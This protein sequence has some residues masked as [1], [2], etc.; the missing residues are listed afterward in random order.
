MTS[1]PRVVIAGFG[2]TGVLVG[3]HLSRFADVVGISAKPGVVSGQ[4]LGLRLAHPEVWRRDYWVPFEHYRRLDGVRTVHG[5]LTGMDPDRQRVQVRMLD[6]TVREEPYDVLVVATGVSNGFWR[7]PDV[8]GPES[9]AEQLHRHHEQFAAAASIA[10]VGGGAAAVSSAWNMAA[11]WPGTQ[12]DLYFPGERA[13]VHHHPRVWATLGARL[14]DRGVGLHPGHR[15]EIPDGFLG[16]RIT[17][18]PIH[19]ISGQRPAQAD[20]VL[21]AVGRVTPNT[22]WL[23][24]SLLDEH[25][26]VRTD[27]HL[28]VPGAAHVYAVGDV[29]ATDPLRTSAR[30]RADHLVA[31]NI[32]AEFG[33]GT[34]RSF[35]PLKH[36]WGSVLGAQD[37]RLEVFSPR[38]RPFVLP[39]WSLL[40]PWVVRRG[41]YGGIRDGVS[42]TSVQP[43]RD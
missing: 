24:P 22:G 12:I 17:R 23:P 1:R 13:L 40:Q 15:A 28:R 31:H 5:L 8:Q 4:E 26:F 14:Q 11:R 36:R 42:V 32:R 35:R 25:G 21:W 2:D 33:H 18:G 10:V 34:P 37:N 9:V 16:E 27:A 41:I 7:T 29:A 20:A 39:A 38:G 19:W 6:A 3:I 30:A 43:R